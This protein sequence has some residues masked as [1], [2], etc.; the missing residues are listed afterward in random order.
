MRIARFGVASRVVAQL[1]IIV[2]LAVLCLAAR[3]GLVL[4]VE[5]AS[6][7]G[8]SGVIQTSGGANLTSPAGIFQFGF[9]LAPNSSDRYGVAIWYAQLP[10]SI[11]TVVWIL[12]GRNTTL[13]S[14]AYLQL[15]SQG[16]V[17]QL[18]DPGVSTQTPVWQSVNYNGVSNLTI[19]MHFSCAREVISSFI[20]FRREHELGV[21]K[22][23]SINFLNI[24]GFCFLYVC[25]SLE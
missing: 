6:S 14:S 21:L 23:A 13:S 7:L 15:N 19:F 20:H 8:L 24:L 9:Y 1:R 5:G 25:V 4:V 12:A 17:L 22:V 16:G 18:F 3:R 10:R 2:L 11:R